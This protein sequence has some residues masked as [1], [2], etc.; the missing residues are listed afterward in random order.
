LSVVRSG[1]RDRKRTFRF[2]PGFQRLKVAQRLRV[3]LYSDGEK[4]SV[5]V[6]S[7]ER[8]LAAIFAADIAGYSRLMAR[9]EEGT[10]AP[11]KAI[12]PELSGPKITDRR[13][14]WLAQRAT[15]TLS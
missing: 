3:S 13:N 1:G 9:D 11:L 14:Q 2:S 10:L 12:R 15:L 5:P 6:H 7:V 8:K 4:L